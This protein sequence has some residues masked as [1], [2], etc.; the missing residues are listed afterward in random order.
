MPIS[1]CIVRFLLS[2]ATRWI[3]CV[4]VL[5]VGWLWWWQPSSTASAGKVSNGFDAVTVVS[6][7]GT[8]QLRDFSYRQWPI[9]GKLTSPWRYSAYRPKASLGTLNSWPWYDSYNDT[10]SLAWGKV[11]LLRWICR[12][13]CCSM[14]QPWLQAVSHLIKLLSDKRLQ[15][16]L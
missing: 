8:R 16:Q 15:I 2:P 1:Q 3:L 6:L 7:I 11:Q 12:S 13:K 5:P 10:M 4:V 9:R 14:I